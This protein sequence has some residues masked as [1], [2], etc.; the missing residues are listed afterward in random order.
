MTRTRIRVDPTSQSEVTRGDRHI[1]TT[2]T[3]TMSLSVSGSTMVT[4]AVITETDVVTSASTG[5]AL[6]DSTTTNHIHV[7]I[8][9]CPDVNGVVPITITQ[10][11]SGS[12]QPAGTSYAT[13]T[14]GAMQATVGDD[15]FLTGDTRTFD[16]TIEERGPSGMRRG[17]ASAGWTSSRAPGGGSSSASGYHFTS[18][19]DYPPG[20]AE[21][22]LGLGSALLTSIVDLV[23]D[24]AQ[25]AWQGGKC[26]RIEATERSRKVRRNEVI[27][28][29]AQPYRKIDGSRL[30]KPVVATFGGE[31]SVTPVD[32]PV[33]APAA[34][35]FTAAPTRKV[36]RIELTSTSNRGIG[37]LQIQFEVED[38]GWFIDGSR[39]NSVGATGT[40]QGKKCGSDPM[41][42]WTLKGTYSFMG[43]DGR[44]TWVIKI[45]DSS[46]PV[47]VEVWT[48]TYTF[49]D[50][51][52]GPYGVTQRIDASGTVKLVLDPN[53]GNAIMTLTQTDAEQTASAPP[54]GYG[55]GPGPGGGPD[56]TWKSDAQC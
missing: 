56:V 6:G 23:L 13:S 28:F 20:E 37:K 5:E 40:L 36:G 47:D 54:A 25:A 19:G 33:D 15:A 17:S 52:K 16:S 14:S 32:T 43:F 45:T 22:G 24:R 8:D 2:L 10:E 42:T 44:Q 31:R 12:S 27:T 3:R 41:G 7:E 35:T 51:S 11:V 55:S 53:D 34:F 26:V 46:I 4:D 49:R 18:S 39:T 50:R 30:D 29:T 21:A 38:R 9:M 1:A 48:G